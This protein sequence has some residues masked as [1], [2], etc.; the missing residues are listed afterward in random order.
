[1]INQVKKELGDRHPITVLVQMT[2]K[3][4]FI[5]MNISIRFDEPTVKRIIEKLEAISN[6]I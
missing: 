4:V 5:I 1:L 6:A 3:L 2:S